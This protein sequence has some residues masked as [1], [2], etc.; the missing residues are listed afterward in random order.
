[1]FTLTASKPHS[2]DM[3]TS[4]SQCGCEVSMSLEC[5]CEAVTVSH[6]HTSRHMSLN[7]IYFYVTYSIVVQLLCSIYVRSSSVLSQLIMILGWR[8]KCNSLTYWPSHLADQWSCMWWDVM[9]RG[10]ISLEDR[11][12]YLTIH[13][14][15]GDTISRYFTLLIF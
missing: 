4:H 11:I 2:K 5:D 14:R 12:Y 6:S 13:L 8:C 9:W 3:E 10:G 15:Q 7:L 1:M